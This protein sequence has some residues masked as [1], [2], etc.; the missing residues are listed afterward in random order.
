MEFL[1]CKENPLHNLQDELKATSCDYDAVMNQAQ[2]L[3]KEEK[4]R[5]F[6]KHK[7][8]ERLKEEA[9]RSRMALNNIENFLRPISTD[10][11]IPMMF[12]SSSQVYTT[13]GEPVTFQQ[14]QQRYNRENNVS[15]YGCY[16]DL[17]KII[18]GVSLQDYLIHSNYSHGIK[19][20]YMALSIDKEKRVDTIFYKLK[21]GDG[22]KI[23]VMLIDID[24]QLIERRKIKELLQTQN[25]QSCSTNIRSL[26]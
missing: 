17:Q 25:V 2:N 8:E 13:R 4:L 14:L 23:K 5:L 10:N 20:D 3:M 12:E 21:S 9:L 18:H 19:Y 22:L 7:K 24:G 1:L 6:K 26:F 11:Y 16:M 15:G